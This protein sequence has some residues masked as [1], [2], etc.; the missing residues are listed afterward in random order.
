MIT[1]DYCPDWS[2]LDAVREYLTNALDSEAK[3]T[4]SVEGSE[5]GTYYLQITSKNTRLK[6][7]CMALGKSTNRSDP[8]A[9]GKHGEGF[10]VAMAVALR[11]GLGLI[12]VNGDVTWTPEFV[13]DNDF[14]VNTLCI[15]EEDYHKPT[16]DFTVVI[17]QLTKQDLEVITERCLYIQDPST[18]GKVLECEMG[19]VFFDRKGKLYVGG[20]WVTDT[21]LDYT[22]DF[23]PSYLHLNRDR[24]TVENWHLKTNVAK[25]LQLVETPKS[26][27]AL[28]EQDKPDVGYMQYV[29]VTPA[30]KEECFKLYENKY[31]G[32]MLVSSQTELQSKISD[33]YSDVV[34]EED[35]FVSLV[36]N[37]ESYQNIKFERNQESPIDFIQKLLDNESIGKASPLVENTLRLLLDEFNQRGVRWGRG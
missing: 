6:S 21:D 26:I 29:Q 3:F 1:E 20:V 22:Y 9:V 12:F 17:S 36:K 7:S 34:V 23:H 28:V 2:R 16:E 30:I 25:M 32:K 35:T 37:S 18:F 8:N 13:Y 19:R 33:G 5:D 31:K 15:I 14:E 10:S 24:K 4:W 27:A 11:E